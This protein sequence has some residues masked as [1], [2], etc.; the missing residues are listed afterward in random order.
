[1]NFSEKLRTLRKQFN[2]SQETLAEKITVSRQ[3]IT[4]WET[5]EGLPDIENLMAIAALF[6]IS[7]DE[8]LSAE[9]TLR[10]AKDYSYE[11]VTEL[12]IR[13]ERHF[14]IRACGTLETLVSVSDNEKLR[15][16]LASNVLKNLESDFKVQIDE[17]RNRMDV[18][19][20]RLDSGARGRGGV[21]EAEAK[22]ALFLHIS[23]PGKYCQEAELAL[24]TDLL[25]LEGLAFPFELDGKAGKVNLEAVTG[26]AVLNSGVDMDIY[27]DKLPAALEINQISAASKVHI[28]QGE[29]FFTKIKGKSNR[30]HYAV[31]GKASEPFETPDA[32]RRIEL[33]GMNTELLIDAYPEAGK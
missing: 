9:K 14:D 16:R 32:E 31:N 22:D 25:R 11:S 15:V 28:P 30:I 20:H 23:L 7:M 4:K 29:T 27:C 26:K 2:F 3:A 5:G 10:G 19:I 8:L 24:N 21:R 12:D 6:S 13:G 1:M 18:D 33:A 17:H